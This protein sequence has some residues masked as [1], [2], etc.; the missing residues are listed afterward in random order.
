MSFPI[1]SGSRCHLFSYRGP[2]GY[3]KRSVQQATICVKLRTLETGT[4]RY[5]VD[6]S[7]GADRHISPSRGN[8]DYIIPPNPAPSS[9][10]IAEKDEHLGFC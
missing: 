4:P 5:F 1:P 10:Q 8:P 3:E 7:W 2:G 6:F 9:P